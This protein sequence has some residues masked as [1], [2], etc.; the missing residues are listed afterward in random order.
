MAARPCG[1]GGQIS[2]VI[3]PE[4][5][6]VWSAE[7]SEASR[8]VFRDV[9]PSPELEV[10]ELEMPGPLDACANERSFL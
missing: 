2:G 8:S 10:E 7:D 6:T 5:D 3:W 4:L 1:S 9:V